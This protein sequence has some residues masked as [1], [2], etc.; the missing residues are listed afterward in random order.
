MNEPT[1]TLGKSRKYSGVGNIP[2][3]RDDWTG[4]LGT[5]QDLIDKGWS[6]PQIAGHF[7]CSVHHLTKSIMIASASLRAPSPN[8]FMND[9]PGGLLRIRKIAGRGKY[10][11]TITLGAAI[12]GRSGL[13]VGDTFVITPG[14]GSLTV[15]KI[16]VKQ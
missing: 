11:P 1:P 15:K 16:A 12:L 8:V 6:S 13:K 4:F 5:V 7:E 14:K 3:N 10:G 9:R 2:K